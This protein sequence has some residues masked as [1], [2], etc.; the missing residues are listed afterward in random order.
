MH[1]SSRRGVGL[2]LYAC[3]CVGL[4]SITL[5]AAGCG[6]LAAA[7]PSNQPKVFAPAVQRLDP[8]VEQVAHTPIAQ[9]ISNSLRRKAEEMVVRVRNVNCEGIEIGSGFALDQHTLLTNRH[10]LAGASQLE[11]IHLGWSRLQSLD[12]RGRRTCRSWRSD[13]R[14][15][16]AAGRIYVRRTGCG[17]TRHGRRVP[18]RWPAHL[19]RRPNRRLRRRLEPRRARQGDASD[20]ERRTGKLRRPGT[21]L[22]GQGRRHRLCD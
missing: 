2:M 19:L 15:S 7:P 8:L 20:R 12:G 22:A 14:R 21:R 9:L 13:N 10:V 16:A 6:G 11:G 1:R 17:R 3:A 4:A 18:A 5:A